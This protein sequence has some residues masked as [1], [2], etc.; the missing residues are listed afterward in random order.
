MIT[1]YHRKRVNL[2]KTHSHRMLGKHLASI[3]FTQTPRRYTLAFLTGCI[4]PD[5]NPVTYLKGSI[6]HRMLHGHN[7]T[8]SQKYMQRICRR[9]ERRKKLWLWDFYTLGKLIHYVT[10]A[11]TFTH[12]DWFDRDILTHRYYETDL[13]VHFLK[14]LKNY[15]AP[16]PQTCENVMDAIRNYHA[17]YRQF[18]VSMLADCRYSIL[19]SSMV[20][21]MLVQ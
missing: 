6:H 2:I 16:H 15:N 10:D 11:F 14:S 7:W 9:L 12:N 18:P 20:V 4:Q 8:N 21:A 5:R 17:E 19:V 1:N 13:E 3:Y